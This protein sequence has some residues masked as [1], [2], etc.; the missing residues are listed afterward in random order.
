MSR[1]YNKCRCKKGEKCKW[2]KGEG[3]HQCEF[4]VNDIDEW[5]VR[6]QDAI[7]IRYKRRADS[8]EEIGPC[9]WDD[10]SAFGGESFGYFHVLNPIT[11]EQYDSYGKTWQ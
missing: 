8:E 4:F 1:I 2:A 6:Q 7:D 11:R 9:F 5:V 3:M 10:K